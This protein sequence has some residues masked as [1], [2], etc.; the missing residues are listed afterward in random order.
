MA[1]DDPIAVLKALTQADLAP[2]PMTYRTTVSKEHIDM[3]GHM[4]VRWYFDMFS[5]AV[6]EVYHRFG[7]TQDYVSEQRAGAFALESHIRYLAE[8]REGDD[9]AVYTRFIG[10]SSK[11]F[12]LMQFM[13]NKS[14]DRLAA[15]FESTFAHIDM[16]KRRMSP[17]PDEIGSQFD[18]TLKQH[19]G[20]PWA[21]PVCA[22]MRV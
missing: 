22:S 8:A 5:R 2:L 15:T 10:R 9:V 20:L 12:R 17:L 21:A 11:R 3:M 4:N 18:E 6:G 13:W 1:A 7:I 14:G 19:G 16:K